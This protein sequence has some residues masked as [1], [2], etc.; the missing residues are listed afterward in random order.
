M[1]KDLNFETYLTSTGVATS[2]LKFDRGIVAT[3]ADL[4]VM[5]R[6]KIIV[7][8]KNRVVVVE[9]Y[10][11]KLVVKCDKDDKF[12]LKIGLGLALSHWNNDCKKYRVMREFFRNKKRM[13]DYKKYAN[14]VLLDYCNYSEK[15]VECFIKN[16][17]KIKKG[18]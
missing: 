6:R 1:N 3:I 11:R 5:I 16:N 2:P 15:A 17:V 8:E 13:L 10:C 14:W 12:D 9:D 18:K 4:K 7:D